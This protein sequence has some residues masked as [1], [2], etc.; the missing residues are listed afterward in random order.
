MP[1]LV[2]DLA[3][4]RLQQLADSTD[5]PTQAATAALETAS[6]VYAMCP[7]AQR[8]LAGAD[9]A[10]YLKQ[11]V[12][13][14]QTDILEQ[15]KSYGPIRWIWYLRR[16]PAELFEGSY[17]TTL[18]YDRMLAEALSSNFTADDR[19]QASNRVAF[20]I[21]GTAFRHLTRYVGRG[22][23]PRFHGQLG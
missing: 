12:P 5:W 4:L 3:V 7:P 10:E 16:A 21:D 11:I 2:I 23:L 15:H 6:R 1:P 9:A 17:E 20:R 13:L 18:G 14:V 22:V 8:E 19:S